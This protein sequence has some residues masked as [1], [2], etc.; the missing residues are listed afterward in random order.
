MKDFIRKVFTDVI[1]SARADEEV[2]S[3]YF[4]PSYIQYVDGHALTYADF[5]QHMTVQKRSIKSAKV[6][7]D[8]CIVEG[9]K[10]C[11]VHRVDLIKKDGTNVLAK[12]VAYFEL[13]NGKIVLC[14]ELTHILKGGKEDQNMGSIK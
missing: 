8:H 7:V 9:N 14:D 6:I 2:I 12:V 13:E 3:T 4:S 11:T 5:I 10:I 1:E